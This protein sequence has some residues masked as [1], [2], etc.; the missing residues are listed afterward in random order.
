MNASNEHHT[1]ILVF[2]LSSK[3]EKK[4]KKIQ[5]ADQLFTAFSEHTLRIAVR[6]ELPYFHYSEKEQE[7][8]SFGERFTNAIQDIF[9]R[10]YRQIITI[11][12]DSPQL[13]ASHI[14]RAALLLAQNKS[15]IGPSADGGFYLMGLHRK[16]FDPEKFKDLPWQTSKLAS[17]LERDFLN[18]PFEFVPLERLVDIDDSQDLTILSKYTN[19]LTY[20]IKRIVLS[21]IATTVSY[22]K[23]EHPYIAQFIFKAHQNRGSPLP[24]VA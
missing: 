11:G 5:N 18:T 17:R 6:T 19:Q 23:T 24:M 8:D 10:G 21:L 16:N 14:Q 13:K 22:Y 15:V 12:N 7:G 4:R 3:A 1:A 9:N 2:A 20:C